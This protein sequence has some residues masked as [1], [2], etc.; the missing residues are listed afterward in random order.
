VNNVHGERAGEVRIEPTSLRPENVDWRGLFGA[1]E[2][3]DMRGLMHLVWRRK[4]LII[5]PAFLGLL[6]AA[7]GLGQI[8]PRYYAEA[9]VLIDPRKEKI[10][11]VEQV[12]AGL[13]GDTETI[14]SEI[15]VIQ[16]RTLANRVIDRLR[17]EQNPELNADLR[18]P[19]TSDIVIGR[20]RDLVAGLRRALVKLGVSAGESEAE[21]VSSEEY[22]NL[23]RARIVDE[24]LDRLSVG[25]AGKSRVISIGFESQSPKTAADVVNTISELYLT[26]QL[27]AKYEATQQA[28]KWL[29]E[30]LA[31][32]R[33]QVLTAERAVE[34]FREE[35]NLV[36]GGKDVTLASQQLSE[37]NTQV[38]AAHAKRAEAEARLHQIEPLLSSNQGID[39]VLEVIQSPLIQRLREQ[40]AEVERKIAEMEATYGEAYPRMIEARAE[41]RDINKT[42]QSEIAKIVQSIRNEVSVAQAQEETLRRRVEQ[43]TAEVAHLDKAEVQMR[44]L[45]RE[46]DANRTLFQTFLSRAKETGEAESL[47][48]PDATILSRADIPE[49]PVYPKRLTFLI[50]GFAGGGFLGSVLVWLLHYLDPGFRTREQ[51]EEWTG[52]TALASIPGLRGSARKAGGPILHVVENPYSAYSEATRNLYARL[53]PDGKDVSPKVLLMTSAL[54]R[55]GKTSVVLSLAAVAA[56]AGS[57]VI[58]VDGDSRQPDGHAVLGVPLRPGLTDYLAGETELENIIHKC[59]SLG[60]HFIPA[61]GSFQNP[62]KVFGSERL[63]RLLKGLAKGYDLVLVDSAPIL[64]VFETRIASRLADEVVLLIRWG[65]T[66]VEAARAALKELRAANAHVA[67]AVLTIVDPRK[68]HLHGYDDYYM[69]PALAAYHTAPRRRQ[70]SGRGQQK[71]SE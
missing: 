60:I 64:A 57:R 21:P 68:Q 35:N 23:V 11:D 6:L 52:V 58:V 13:P 54:P 8:T 70:D 15:L 51:I 42:I 49:K 37:L 44:A 71:P 53:F 40:Q 29:N 28:H 38:V 3:L 26:A 48:K 67:G 63:R 4:M 55:E 56:A 66:P 24:L 32:L 9:Q 46:A 2:S 41:A 5:V 16:S 31:A 43:L 69:Y 50:L 30:R 62:A 14:Q 25:V 65:K 22:R 59:D 20:M 36:G 19:R 47:Q 18:E 7:W 12:L 33:D 34:K 27:E 39:S 61:G 10:V 1:D 45:E 17:L